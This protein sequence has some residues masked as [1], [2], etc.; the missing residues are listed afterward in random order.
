M[1]IRA[2][3]SSNEMIPVIGL[4]T[5]KQFDIG[6]STEERKPCFEVLKKMSDAGS[7]LIDSSPMYGR[8]EE[9][10][11]DLMNE[12]GDAEQFFYA[13]KVWTTGEQEGIN[14]MNDSMRKMRR[15]RMDL[16]QIHNLV[17][18][19]THLKTM[20]RWK[21]E[22]KIRYIGITHYTV[23]S[24][25]ELERIIKTTKLDF[26]QFNYSIRT[27]NAEKSLLNAARDNG[28]AVIVNEPLEKGLLFNAVKRISLPE[29]SNEYDINSWG[30]FFLKYI[31]AHPAVTCIIPATA[32]PKHCEDNLYAGLGK[33]P[34][35]KGRKRMIEFMERL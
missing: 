15:T 28:V 27:R 10:V 35:E 21:A 3:P 6:S 13:T 17:D 8:S 20:N 23:S 30:E 24:H 26:V 7:T 9:V 33:L 19:K 22:G 18:W 2:I 5:W 1:I 32:D 11:G 31:I 25:D 12:S 4:G 29:W 16:M 14:Q 34:D